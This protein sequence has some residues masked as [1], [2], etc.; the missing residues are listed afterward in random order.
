VNYNYDEPEIKME[1]KDMR[2]LYKLL[3]SKE[4]PNYKKNKAILSD[5]SSMLHGE[6]AYDENVI[7]SVRDLLK[8]NNDA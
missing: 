5:L 7:I 2:R 8:T 4:D 3:C 1:N 6:S